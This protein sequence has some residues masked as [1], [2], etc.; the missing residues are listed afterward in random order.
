MSATATSMLIEGVGSIVTPYIFID[1][2]YITSLAL[3]LA[4]V[5]QLC[6]SGHWLFFSYY[7][8]C[9]L[10]SCS[11]RVVRTGRRVGELYVLDE[12]KEFDMVASGV[13]LSSFH[14]S[15]SSPDSYQWHSRLGH[16]S[17]SRLIFSFWFPY[18]L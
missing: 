17:S 14:L 12:L 7:V 5:S 9:V 2:Y 10:D 13:D 8:C 16:V 6:K 4:S 11:M 15:R 3:N 18:V 1:V